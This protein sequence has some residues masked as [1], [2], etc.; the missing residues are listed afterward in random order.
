MQASPTS[1]VLCQFHQ[2]GQ[3]KNGQQC[4][5]LHPAP[6]APN[7]FVY[8][9]FTL[10]DN[11]APRPSPTPMCT[12][13]L[14]GHCKY[15]NQCTFQ[16]ITCNKCGKPGHFAKQC[17]YIECKHCQKPGHLARDCTLR[18]C[19][20]CGKRGHLAKECTYIECKNCGKPGHLEKECTQRECKKC[21][22]RGHLTKNC[23][24]IE[25]KKCGKPGHLAKDCTYIECSNCGKP[26]HLRSECSLKP[27]K[28]PRKPQ[29]WKDSE[30]G[31]I[32]SRNYVNVY[33]NLVRNYE[34]QLAHYNACKESVGARTL[35]HDPISVSSNVRSYNESYKQARKQERR[36]DNERRAE[37]AW[38]PKE[39]YVPSCGKCGECIGGGCSCF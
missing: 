22:K 13:F 39:Y 17:T 38:K 5:F 10:I 14:Q 7:R 25:C 26:G 3:C 1:G 4:P 8:L 34:R 19:R 36:E 35:N 21:G 37:M 28:P 12:F 9:V 2:R 33:P 29:V 6:S 24:Y 32:V 20:N 23:T 27:P 11:S 30:T 31:G 16:H 18:E 15:G